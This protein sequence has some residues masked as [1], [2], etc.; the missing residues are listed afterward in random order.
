MTDCSVACNT[1]QIAAEQHETPVRWNSGNSN[2]SL[3]RFTVLTRKRTPCSLKVAEEAC[4][5]GQNNKQN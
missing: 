1:N 3:K 4:I 5:D 2:A